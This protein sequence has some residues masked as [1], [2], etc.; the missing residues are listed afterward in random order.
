MVPQ[1]GWQVPRE[2]GYNE[3]MPLCDNGALPEGMKDE[4][5][6]AV[7]V[8]L[9]GVKSIS[10]ECKLDMRNHEYEAEVAEWDRMPYQAKLFV[11]GNC[12]NRFVH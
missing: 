1:Q 8:G 7:C 9:K 3:T 6:F 11:G 4:P 10:D 5:L 12:V 2:L